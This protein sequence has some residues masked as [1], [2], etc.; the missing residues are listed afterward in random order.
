M[1][2]T[3]DTHRLINLLE[4]EFGNVYESIKEDDDITEIK[5]RGGE[6]EITIGD[7]EE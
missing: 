5:V 7:E 2:V 3:I 4:A 1:I 6:V